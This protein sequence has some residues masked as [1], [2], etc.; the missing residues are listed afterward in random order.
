MSTG[1]AWPDMMYDLSKRWPNCE[2]D[3]QYDPS[4][5]GFTGNVW[6]PLGIASFFPEGCADINGCGTTLSYPYWLS[7][8]ITMGFIMLNLIVFYILDSFARTKVTENMKQLDEEQRQVLV[9]TW[10]E[11]DDNVD[12]SIGSEELIDFFMLMPEPMGFG[13]P[14]ELTQRDKEQLARESKRCEAIATLCAKVG[15]R[16]RDTNEEAANPGESA[17]S[18]N[19]VAGSAPARE[20]AGAAPIE[21]GE[22][23]AKSGTAGG[24][25]AVKHLLWL[26]REAVKREVL[27]LNIPRKEMGRVSVYNV[28]DVG[29][30]A[31]QLPLHVQCHSSPFCSSLFLLSPFSCKLHP[32]HCLS[33]TMV[34]YTTLRLTPSNYIPSP[35]PASRRIHPRPPAHRSCR[36]RKACLRRR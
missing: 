8:E 13:P 30:S 20:S 19:A 25:P 7:F 33:L 4:K 17:T 29:A 24:L 5:C 10:C 12:G 11:F 1:E 34:G 36:N 15:C 6:H 22:T 18:A 14:I 26:E 27:A 28:S 23:E 31:S 32:P 35:P 9:M 3:P 21:G 2:V 16:T